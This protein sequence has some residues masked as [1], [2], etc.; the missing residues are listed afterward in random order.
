[1]TR[2]DNLREFAACHFDGETRDMLLEAAEDVELLDYAE[3]KACS[4][5]CN[6]TDP[7]WTFTPPDFATELPPT[8]GDTLRDAIRAARRQEQERTG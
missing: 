8:H 2:A 1:M 5:H 3:S 7:A 6:Y 4:V